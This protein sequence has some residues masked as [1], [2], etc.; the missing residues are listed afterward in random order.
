MGHKAA[1]PDNQMRVRLF[2]ALRE[3]AGWGERQIR[4]DTGTASAADLWRA[5]RPPP[6]CAPG[7]RRCGG[8]GRAG[9]CRS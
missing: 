5:G 7:R 8:R 3:H 9:S 6:P 2:A 4:L 1:P